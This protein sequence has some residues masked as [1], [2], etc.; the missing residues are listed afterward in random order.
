[1][2]TCSMAK[3]IVVVE[4]EYSYVI[5]EDGRIEKFPLVVEYDVPDSTQ[6][7]EEK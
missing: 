1:M 6:T 2:Y 7:T 5:M 4:G 3:K